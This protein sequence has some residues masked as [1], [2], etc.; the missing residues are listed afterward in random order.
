[1]GSKFKIKIKIKNLLGKDIHV[2]R[3]PW[4]I[5]Q[6]GETEDIGDALQWLNKREPKYTGKV[7]KPPE[8][9]L[10]DWVNTKDLKPED[11]E[12]LDNCKISS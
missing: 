4:G 6:E 1:M 7:Q 11:G 10:K 8:N 9:W 5:L 12:N 2:V 3:D